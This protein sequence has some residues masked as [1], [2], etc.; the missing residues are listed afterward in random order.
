MVI[1]VFKVLLSNKNKLIQ[2][3]NFL[4]SAEKN[5]YKYFYEPKKDVKSI[6]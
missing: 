2:K 3:M 4:T 1:T 5:I 6:V